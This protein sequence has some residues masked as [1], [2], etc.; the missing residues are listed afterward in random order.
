MRAFHAREAW[1]VLIVMVAV[2]ATLSAEVRR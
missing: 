2:I 1:V